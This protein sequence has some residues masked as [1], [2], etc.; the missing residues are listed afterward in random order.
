M[1]LLTAITDVLFP[2]WFRRKRAEC[3]NCCGA[4][5]N[6]TVQDECITVCYECIDILARKMSR[7]L[8]EGENN[9]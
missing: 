4:A 2:L 3:C 5:N 8:N 6:D 7:D 9:E 1:S